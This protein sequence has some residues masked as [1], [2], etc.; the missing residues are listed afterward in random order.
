M[1]VVIYRLKGSND[2]HEPADYCTQKE[3]ALA[4]LKAFEEMFLALAKLGQLESYEMELIDPL[5]N[6]GYYR[7]SVGPL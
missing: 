3:E 1:W 5:G 4:V 2:K 6:C 7:S